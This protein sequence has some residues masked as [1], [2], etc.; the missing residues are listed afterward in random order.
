MTGRSILLVVTILLV[1]DAFV[2]PR[3]EPTAL[4]LRGL[5][6][7]YQLGFSP[8]LRVTKVASCRFEPTC[9]VYGAGSI[10]KYGTWIGGARTIWRVIR[11]N[12]WGGSGY[13]PP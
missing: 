1:I 12:P 9:S 4:L 11:C 3:Y 8:L 2:P 6:R 5:I 10:E 7:V 13:D